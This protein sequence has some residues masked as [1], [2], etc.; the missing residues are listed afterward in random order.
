[1]L[2]AVFDEINFTAF[3]RQKI[4]DRKFN[5]NDSNFS[6]QFVKKAYLKKN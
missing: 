6:K 3:F 5:K 4:W 1:M 2:L